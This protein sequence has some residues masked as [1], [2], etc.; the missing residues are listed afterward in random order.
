[1]AN[2]T[3]TE[4]HEEVGGGN[5]SYHAIDEKNYPSL[6]QIFSLL[7]CLFLFPVK[8]LFGPNTSLRTDRFKG[9]TSRNGPY[10]LQGAVRTDFRLVI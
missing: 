3:V 4:Q 8:T 10:S 1:M 2:V 9:G 6:N 5:A 7:L